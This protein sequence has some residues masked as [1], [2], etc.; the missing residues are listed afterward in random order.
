MTT[1]HHDEHLRDRAAMVALRGFMAASETLPLSP[2]GRPAYDALIARTPGPDGVDW[3]AGEV[4]GVVGWWCRP[5]EAVPGRAI[6]YLHGGGYVIGSA[7]AYRGLASQIAVRAR[8]ATFVADYGLAP[9]HPF[10]AAFDDALRALDGLA[11]AGF[12]SVA[13]AGDSAG[14]GLS[15]AVLASRAAAT[16]AVAVA[17]LSPWIDLSLSGESLESRASADPILSPEGLHQLIDRY[18]RDVDPADPR[19]NP[20]AGDLSILPPVRVDVGDDEILLA[21]SL[22]FGQAADA[23][24]ISCE[25]H[26][27]KG[28]VHVF[29]TNISMLKAATEALNGIGAFLASAFDRATAGSAAPLSGQP[30]VRADRG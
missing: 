8:A 23:A 19:V 2:E 11:E 9:E 18:F 27:W 28:M 3:S 29:P 16:R 15:L 30:G 5:A 4:G 21:D 22:R 6:L 1:I 10:P 25:V 24:G 7:A 14:G 13:L 20:L 12:S 17:V 26:V